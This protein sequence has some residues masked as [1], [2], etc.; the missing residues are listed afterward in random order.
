MKGINGEDV[1]LN[2]IKSELIVNG[3]S[4][5]GFRDDEENII[6]EI[7]GDVDIEDIEEIF[8]ENGIEPVFVDD[9]ELKDYPDYEEA[10]EIVD[11][12]ED[13]DE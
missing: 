2:D 11:D 10:D 1:S 8:I 4:V 12:S 7:S 13:L 3:Y 9:N 5:R 6:M